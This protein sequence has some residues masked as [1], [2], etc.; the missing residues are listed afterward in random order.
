M[1]RSSPLTPARGMKKN[2][3]CGEKGEAIPVTVTV[4]DAAGRPQANT[5]VR[6][7]RGFSSSRSNTSVST[8]AA[9]M[10]LTPTSPLGTVLT[11]FTGNSSLYEATGEDGMLQLTLNQDNTTGLKTTI[12]ASPASDSPRRPAKTPPLPSLPAPDVASADYWGICRR[13][14]RDRITL[15]IS[16]PTCR[17]KHRRG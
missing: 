11:N 4:T 17:Q 6:V 3:L 9:T 1:S 5:V 7:M 2:R 15:F 8:S 13:R 16:V 10:T 12:T 14:C